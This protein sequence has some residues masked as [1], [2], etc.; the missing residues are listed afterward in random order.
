VITDRNAALGHHLLHVA[1][2]QAES[3]IQQDG[4][5]DDLGG[6]TMASIEVGR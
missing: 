4:V 6:K 2:T 5:A 1:V 3:K